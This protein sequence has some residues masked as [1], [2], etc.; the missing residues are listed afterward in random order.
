MCANNFMTTCFIAKVAA[1]TENGIVYIGH[2]EPPGDTNGSGGNSTFET[3]HSVS[4]EG[5]SAIS[6]CPD[7]SMLAIG[8]QDSMIYVLLDEKSHGSGG[9]DHSS[10]HII[11]KL[12]GHTAGITHIDWA[13]DNHHLRSNSSDYE[14]LY[15]K[16][17]TSD[18]KEGEIQ[19]SLQI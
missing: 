13:N 14:L 4:D 15:W 17:D 1:G 9:G 11:L 7:G 5:I 2:L 8:A 6:F 10:N 19:L 3:H 12:S 18:S 16:V